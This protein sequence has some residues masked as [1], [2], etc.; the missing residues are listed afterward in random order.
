MYDIIFL[1]I[2]SIYMQFNIKICLFISKYISTKST[3]IQLLLNIY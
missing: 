1:E 2:P 3:R